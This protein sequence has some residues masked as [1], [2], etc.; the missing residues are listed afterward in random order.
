MSLGVETHCCADTFG[1]FGADDAVVSGQALADVVQQGADQEQVR[2]GDGT[3]QRGRIRR[4][5]DEVT[6]DGEAVVRIVLR[7]AAHMA[8]VRQ[9]L[10]EDPGVIQCL[11]YGYRGRPGGEQ[12]DERLARFERPRHGHR[13]ALGGQPRKRVRGE[14]QVGDRRRAGGSKHE[15]GIGRRVGRDGQRHLAVVLDDAFV[16]AAADDLAASP[17]TRLDAADARYHAVFQ[18]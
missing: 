7:P 12:P 10:H 16:Q 14:R 3:G 13:S 15:D 4:G 9:Q 2:P 11:D 17:A 18:A 6:I 8:P 5:L 1:H